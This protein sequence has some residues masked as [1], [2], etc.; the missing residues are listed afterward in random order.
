MQLVQTEEGFDL[1][2]EKTR[3][4]RCAVRPAAG[5]ARGADIGLVWVD[6]AWRR[7]GYGT[8]LLRQLL[9]RFG[10]YDRE[11][12][13]L[14][15]APLPADEGERAFWAAFGFAP[16]GDALVRRRRPDLTAVRF[17]Q[18]F[19]AQH[20]A[21][22]RLLIDATCGNGGDT[23]FLC[24]LTGAEGRVLAF[25]IQQKALDATR[26][27]LAREGL[28]DGRCRLILDSH[29]HLL[30]YAAPGSA[31]GVMFNFGWLPGA[32]H[33]V[34]SDA[35]SSIPALAA[36]L[37]ALRPGGVLSAVLYSGAVIGD[38]EKQAALRWMEALPIA[39]YTVLTCRFANWADTA[40]LPCL[41][42]KK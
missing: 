20:L 15:T 14:F 31:D 38:R 18:D 40:P 36:A 19:L 6:P 8:Y 28:D 25:D 9:H 17:A 12:E 37:D 4:G 16:E 29:E 24:R 42:L 3:V 33:A 26:A 7:R 5:P 23:A 35:A 34:H 41:V 32:D 1:Y 30:R 2:K 13:S 22:P 10:G 11:A 21:R 39:R 27:R